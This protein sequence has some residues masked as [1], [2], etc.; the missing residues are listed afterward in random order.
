MKLCILGSQLHAGP[1]WCCPCDVTRPSHTSK[2]GYMPHGA[3]VLICQVQR[4]QNDRATGMKRSEERTRHESDG[5]MRWF[6]PD[7]EGRG[8]ASAPRKLNGGK[9]VAKEGQS[10]SDRGWKPGFFMQAEDSIG[11]RNNTSIYSRRHHSSDPGFKQTSPSPSSSATNAQQPVILRVPSM[12]TFRAANKAFLKPEQRVELAR[13]LR[14]GVY[15]S[16]YGL[17]LIKMTQIM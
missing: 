2:R 13:L 4:T 10:L 6:E 16:L 7:S 9:E 15:L 1:A 14:T 3:P 17:S 8:G 11:N 5:N 12:P